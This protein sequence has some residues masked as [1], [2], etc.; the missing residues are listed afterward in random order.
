MSVERRSEMEKDGHDHR[1]RS[2]GGEKGLSPNDCLAGHPLVQLRA[3]S[4][5]YPIWL[6]DVLD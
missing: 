5:S 1:R 6:R 2:F 4:H 3:L